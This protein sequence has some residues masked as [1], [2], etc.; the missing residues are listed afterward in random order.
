MGELAFGYFITGLFAIIGAIIT[1]FA[2]DKDDLGIVLGIFFG[3][4]FGL[5]LYLLPMLF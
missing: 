1:Y 2:M 5:I 4:T 3:G